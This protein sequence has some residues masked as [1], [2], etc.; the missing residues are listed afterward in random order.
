MKK[1]RSRQAPSRKLAEKSRRRAA[2]GVR[3]VFV[4]AT[5]EIAAEVLA[6]CRAVERRLSPEQIAEYRQLR[7]AVREAESDDEMTRVDAAL[8]ALEATASYTDDDLAQA[9]AE[10]AREWQQLGLVP[11]V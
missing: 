1:Q 7:Q 8:R 10:V 4:S 9:G 6:H 2:V 3:V 11:H 5:Q